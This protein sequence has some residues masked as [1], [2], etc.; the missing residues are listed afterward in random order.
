MRVELVG[1]NISVPLVT[2][3]L[4][5]LTQANQLEMET[6]AAAGLPLPWLYDA[7]V[8]YVREAPGAERWQ[9]AGR[10]LRRRK[11]DCEDLTAYVAAWLRTHGGEP[12]ARAFAVDGGPN[13]IH[14]L[15][16]REDGSIMDPS[17]D[18]G[19]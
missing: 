14:C 1:L 17:R 18:L 4:E 19:M 15:V 16:E 12:N 3:M 7:G 6:M 5:A 13:T 10:V 11:G 8:R 9:T 2:A